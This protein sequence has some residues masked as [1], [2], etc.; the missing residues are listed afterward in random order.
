MS[1]QQPSLY[2]EEARFNIIREL[3]ETE[4]KY[5]Q[6]LDILQKYATAVAQ[7]KLLDEE[8]AELLFS[9]VPPLLNFHR[10]FLVGLEGTAELPWEE[11]RWGRHFVRAEQDFGV[12]EPY[13]ANYTKISGSSYADLIGGNEQSLVVFDHLMSATYELPAFLIKP[14]GRVCKYPLLLECLLKASSAASYDH[15]DELKSGLAASRRV[16]NNTN[17]ASRRAEN[18][19]TMKYLR[20]RVVDWKGL[21]FDNFGVL[22]LD[23]IFVVTRTGVDREYHVFLFEQIILCCKDTSKA[24]RSILRRPPR[25]NTSLV[26]KGQIYLANVTQAEVVASPAAPT[27]EYLLTVWFREGDGGLASFTLHC[28]GEE[29]LRQWQTQLV[30]LI[31][32]C[33]ERR[34]EDHSNRPRPG[35]R[36]VS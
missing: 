35:S 31:R 20:T 11:Q 4:R 18:A 2:D 36:G 34:A 16:A 5:V 3:V 8:T 19:Q 24:P 23:D 27:S 13:C 9:N 22:L 12:Y 15:Y 17:E 14:V 10:K 21:R 28:R 29:H 30:R 32:E 26:L 7:S 33:A 6:D 25:R 1:S